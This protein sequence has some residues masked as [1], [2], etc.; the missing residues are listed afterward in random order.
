M[1]SG[2]F[3]V[4]G[5]DQQN[6]RMVRP[7]PA[8][9]NWT[10]GLLTQ[11]GVAPGA[12]IEFLPSQMHLN[13]VFPHRTEDTSVDIAHTVNLNGMPPN[14]SAAGMPPLYPTVALAFGGNVAHNSQWNG[15]CQGVYVP[16][17]TLVNSLSAISISRNSI[18]FIEEFDNITGVMKLKAVVND[19]TL[20]YKLAVSSALLKSAWRNGGLPLLQNSLPP[21]P[22]F[23][24]RL[25]L[26]RA[27]D[28]P[29]SRC[30]M[31]VNGV[32]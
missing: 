1:S 12:T 19:G 31:M 24:I 30:Y 3:C 11:F 7:L 5:W 18:V 32:H 16:V 4:A 22:R 17:G 15:I 8:G 23:C 13:G 28:N 6:Q 10:L 9:S 14:W 26:A 21:G 25:G 2:N 27:F 20:R 29:P